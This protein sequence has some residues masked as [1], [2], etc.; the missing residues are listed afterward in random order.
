MTT[1]TLA[2]EIMVAAIMSTPL[3]YME[4]TIKSRNPG[5]DSVGS[6][7]AEPQTRTTLMAAD[8]IEVQD[9]AH[10]A[11]G[12]RCFVAEIPGYLGAVPLTELDEAELVVAPA[13]AG[14]IRGEAEVQ[15][16]LPRMA[17]FEQPVQQFTYAIVGE[18]EG[19]QVVYTMHPGAPVA[20]PPKIQL[21]DCGGEGAELTVAEAI[22]LG[23][24]T[25]K[26]V[27]S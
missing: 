17:K 26:L 12:C 24:K 6:W 11:P 1:T 14:G 25:A 27:F 20:M 9:Q 19:S 8:W 22:A 21:A 5:P 15:L 3:D 7:W 16:H 10:V 23:F 18:H 4:K 2:R 13:H